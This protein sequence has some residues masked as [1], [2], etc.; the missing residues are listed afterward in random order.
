LL[1]VL[2][3]KYPCRFC[4]TPKNE[5]Q[6]QT[7]QDDNSLRN[8]INCLDDVI[9]DDVYRTGIK[10]LCE[11]S[12]VESFDVTSNYSVDIMHDML[13]EVCKCDVGFLLKELIFN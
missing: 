1:K 7:K 5:C 3:P 9:T 11:W 6:N 13:D 12:E 10:E 2:L 8:P 4:K